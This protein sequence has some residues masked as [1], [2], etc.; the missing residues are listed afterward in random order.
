MH[1]FFL[2]SYWLT[3][4]LLCALHQGVAQDRSNPFEIVS[5]L[6]PPAIT[7]STTTETTTNYSPFDIRQPG[8]S[9]AVPLTTAPAASPTADLDTQQRGPLVIQSADPNRGKGS[10]LAIQLTLLITLASIWVLFGGLL[11]QCFQ[12]M[13]NDSLMNQIYPR[14]SGGEVSALW[15]CYLF[16]FL[17]A[18]F[19]LYLTT[20]Y[21]GISINPNVW[22]SWLTYS[23]IVASAMGLKQLVVHII[24]RLFPVRKE[25]SRYAFVLMVFAILCG[26]LLVPVNLGLSYAPPGA[27]ALFLYGGAALLA[28]VYLLHLA[29]GLFIIGSLAA[30][31]PLHILLYICAVEI[32]PLLIIYRYLSSSLA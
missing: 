30:G 24:G 15:L 31:R 20:R 18:G 6:P 4:L 21:F 3:L 14:R 22:M 28:V 19:Y 26:V 16:F 9:A 23:L 2:R 17:A 1:V 13:F 25:A 8:T 10:V 7:D 5:R 27:R 12:G 11:R 29:R 32:A